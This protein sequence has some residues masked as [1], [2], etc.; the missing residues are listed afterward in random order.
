MSKNQLSLEPY[1]GYRGAMTATALS[2]SGVTRWAASPP[3][4]GTGTQKLWAK[5]STAGPRSVWGRAGAVMSSI[6][7]PS[8]SGR[9]LAPALPFV[10]LTSLGTRH[11]RAALAA[12]RLPERVEASFQHRSSERLSRREGLTIKAAAAAEGQGFASDAGIKYRDLYCRLMYMHSA[13]I[14]A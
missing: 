3:I 1:L 14:K 7:V 4:I 8:C 9:I 5:V 13:P 11:R 10:Q 12:C 6:M 2:K